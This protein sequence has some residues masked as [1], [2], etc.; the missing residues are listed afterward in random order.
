[1]HDESRQHAFQISA[2][3]DDVAQLP[4]RQILVLDSTSKKHV[5]DANVGMERV[6]E[7]VVGLL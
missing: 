2:I 3:S 1:M 7:A 4:G 6:E 5:T